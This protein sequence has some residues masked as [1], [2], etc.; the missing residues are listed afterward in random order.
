MVYLAYNNKEVDGLSFA[1]KTV[2]LLETTSKCVNLDSV[3]MSHLITSIAFYIRAEAK[4][5]VNTMKAETQ[6]NLREFNYL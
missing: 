5:G 4:I 3:C 1:E 6:L 2:Y